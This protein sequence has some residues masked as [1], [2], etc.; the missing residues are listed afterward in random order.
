MSWIVLGI[1]AQTLAAGALLIDKAV[2]S[3]FTPHPLTLLTLVGLSNLVLAVV[4]LAS[5]HWPQAA[6]GDALSAAASGVLL[7]GYLVPYFVA[8]RG[9][10]ASAVGTLFQLAPLW[11]LLI[12]A[13]FLG[14]RPT[15]LQ[16]AGF[17]TVLAG[18]LSIELA[19]TS[20]RPHGVTVGLMVVSTLFVAIG[21]VLAKHA[22]Q[23]GD[24]W[25]VTLFVSLGAAAGAALALLVSPSRSV[26]FGQLA[27]LPAA[28]FFAM[29]L[30]ETLNLG[31]EVLFLSAISRGPVGLV[32]VTEGAQPV[33][34]VLGAA[35][36]AKR[37][38]DL[39][40]ERTDP[41]TLG[42]RLGGAVVVVVGLGLL[43]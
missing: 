11:T 21:A 23:G 20:R 24:F 29:A 39:F 15:S 27:S 30:V 42:I 6:P 36:L 22:Y 26:V 19:A 25:G 13:L 14:E 28:V 32:S 18:A 5:R 9:A 34:L 8:L 37:W 33:L 43:R 17:A 1:L 41:R 35:A 38:P 4:V 2:I 31:F 40:N 3:C 7:V 10:D 12:A 16:F